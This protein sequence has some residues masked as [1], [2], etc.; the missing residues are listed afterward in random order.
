MR[1]HVNDGEQCDR[2]SHQLVE[3]DVLVELA[4]H[5]LS[6]KLDGKKKCNII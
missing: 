1:P 2:I 3:C 5:V 4:S 6:V